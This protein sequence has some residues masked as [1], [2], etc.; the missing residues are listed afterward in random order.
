M[1]H[2]TMSPTPGAGKVNPK[3]LQNGVGPVRSHVIPQDICDEVVPPDFYGDGLWDFDVEQPWE[4]ARGNRS[5]GASFWVSREV[6]AF[7]AVLKK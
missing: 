6:A 2:V 3:I 1:L 7:A 5:P 4:D